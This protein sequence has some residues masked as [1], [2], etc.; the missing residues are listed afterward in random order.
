MP[1]ET[2][3]LFSCFVFKIPFYRIS[4]SFLKTCFSLKSEFP[5]RARNIELS[6]RLSFRFRSVPAKLAFK[7]HQSRDSFGKFF[8]R[9][10]AAGSDIDRLGLALSLSF[11]RK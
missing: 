4:K 6:A 7:I 1:I 8:N 5:L 10:F 11:V 2:N 9:D 3:F